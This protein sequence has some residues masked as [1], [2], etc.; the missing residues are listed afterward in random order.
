[1]RTGVLGFPSTDTASLTATLPLLGSV[2][3]G[4]CCQ[5][6]FVQNRVIMKNCE[7]FASSSPGSVAITASTPPPNSFPAWQRRVPILAAANAAR[8]IR[9]CNSFAATSSP[10]KH[11]SRSGLRFAALKSVQLKAA[12]CN[13]VAP[14]V[15]HNA[16]LCFSAARAIVEKQ[17]CRL[18]W[19]LRRR[20]AHRR[21]HRAAPINA[22]ALFFACR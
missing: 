13:C 22:R 18:C 8:Q 15:L 10:T 17:Q 14:P 7:L 21:R 5:H 11:A 1:M 3:A 9:G 19:G 6:P 16:L 2:T 20:C 4:F 12:L